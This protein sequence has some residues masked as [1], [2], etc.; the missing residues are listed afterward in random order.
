MNILKAIDRLSCFVFG[1]KSDEEIIQI[2]KK[3]DDD[4]NA[5]EERILKLIKE[6]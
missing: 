1:F 4:I 6:I 3:L 2:N 5:C